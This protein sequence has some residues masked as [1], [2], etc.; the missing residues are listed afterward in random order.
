MA[1]KNKKPLR[2]PSLPA[3][4][5]V[6]RIIG[7]TLPKLSDYLFP[8]RRELLAHYFFLTIDASL[9][10]NKAMR[11]IIKELTSIWKAGGVACYPRII[12]RK[13]TSL[14]KDY[15]AISKGL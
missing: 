9:G 12:E 13:I 8:T 10:K 3:G 4:S 11:V 5:A 6:R 14:L 7:P 1:T 15:D 2:V